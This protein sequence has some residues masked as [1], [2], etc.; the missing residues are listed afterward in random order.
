M[1]KEGGCG[2]KTPAKLLTPVPGTGVSPVPFPALATPPRTHFGAVGFS[3]AASNIEDRI[4]ALAEF[5]FY[6]IVGKL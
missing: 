1:K 2:T 4:L 5:S 3:F 6:G